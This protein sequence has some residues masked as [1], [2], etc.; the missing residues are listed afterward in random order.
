VAEREG[1]LDL[2]V[3]LRCRVVEDPELVVDAQEDLTRLP[4]ERW[5]MS[6]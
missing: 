4:L 5:T 6:M 1:L 2:V 3:G